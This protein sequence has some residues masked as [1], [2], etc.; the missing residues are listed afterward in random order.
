MFTNLDLL[1][2]YRLLLGRHAEKNLKTLISHRKKI[3]S[4]TN[5]HQITKEENKIYLVFPSKIFSNATNARGV[6]C[7]T[8]HGQVCTASWVL[9]AGEDPKWR[10]SW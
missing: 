3:Q 4:R 10:R 9:F 7:T 1:H 6:H 8:A 5:C 2:L